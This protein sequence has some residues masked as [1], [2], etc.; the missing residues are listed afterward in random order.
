[1][2]VMPLGLWEWSLALE[3]LKTL[4]TLELSWSGYSL[5]NSLALL[6]CPGFMPCVLSSW[7]KPIQ[8]CLVTA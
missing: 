1:M 2:S 6:T 4:R 5:P 3:P 8:N 7:V